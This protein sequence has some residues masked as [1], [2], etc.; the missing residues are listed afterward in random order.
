MATS[1]VGVQYFFESVLYSGFSKGRPMYSS[2]CCPFRSEK[3]TTIHFGTRPPKSRFPHLWT[4]RDYSLYLF[5]P[6]HFLSFFFFLFSL[7]T[8]GRTLPAH[9]RTLPAH[10]RTL[11][12]Q[13][14]AAASQQS[15]QLRV[16][17]R[18]LREQLT[19]RHSQLTHYASELD[20]HLSQLADATSTIDYEANSGGGSIAEEA[21]V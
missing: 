5:M 17:Q 10:C 13:R 21:K 11:P 19:V 6:F 14:T 9:C 8:C 20:D 18:R 7:C 15:D 4:K 12:A 16:T 3:S 2:V 1:G